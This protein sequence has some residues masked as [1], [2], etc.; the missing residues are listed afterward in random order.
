LDWKHWADGWSDLFETLANLETEE[1][2]MN[3]S[4]SPPTSSAKPSTPLRDVTVRFAGDSGDGM[5]LAGTQFTD[6]SA[7][8]GNDISTLPDFP[9]EIRAPAGTL[10]GVSGYQIHFSST[11]IFTP[12]DEVDALVAMNPAALKTNVRSVKDGGIVIV[13]DDSFAPVDL[14]KAGYESSPL[15]D[16][17][18]ANYRVI[19]VPVDK[20]TLAAVSET[21]LGAKDANRCKN[22][23]ALGLIY[24]LYGRPLDLTLDHINKKFA[25]KPA[26]AQA[27]ILALRAGFNY[28]ETTELFH[29]HYEVPKAK[30][31]PGKYR[32]I[33][34]NEA[35]AMGMI[36]ASKLAG[37]PLLYCS[38]PIT[39]A[40]DI[41]HNLAAEKNFG[42]MTFQAE[43]EIAAIGAAIGAS[44]GGALGATGTSGPG[45]ALKSEA[46]GLAVITELPLVVVDVQRGGPSTGLPTK[47][48]QADLLQVMFGRNGECPIPIIAACSPSDC[49]QAAIEAFTVAVKYMTPVILLSDGYIANGAEPWLVP[50]VSKLAKIVSNHPEAMSNGN[51]FL[52]YQRDENLVRPWAIPGTPGLEHR[53]GGLEKQDITGSVSYDP[54]NHEHMVRLRAGKVAGIVPP[55]QD[56]LMTGP[57]HGDVLLVGWGGTFGAI[58]AAT[59]KLREQGLN[60]SAVHVRYLNPLSEKLG[61]L[62]RNFRRVLAPELNLGQ[63]RLLLRA[64]FLTDVK[65]LNKVRGQPFTIAEIVRGVTQLLEGSNGDGEIRI[66]HNRNVI[67]NFPDGN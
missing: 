9:A 50:D 24:W 2:E 21:G 42:V 44:F 18:L 17:S 14:K 19:R 40:S 62:M 7:A 51:K 54:A 16:G 22:M 66:A 20:L 57:D 8:L 3:V 47:T 53:I 37:K 15:E 1:S 12:G 55:G 61:P 45:I 49:F 5:Q 11:E 36:A 63:L 32:K 26:V 46:M 59:L 58:K 38:Y 25:K 34:G 41:L 56:L 30:L 39:P 28:G 6:T 35:L 31:A 65:G 13:D 52:P 33:T 43:D 23:F 10:A 27:N 4:L 48:E 60:V 67:T 29:E 64:R